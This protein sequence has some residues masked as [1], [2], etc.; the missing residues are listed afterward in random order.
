MIL[1]KAF[2]FLALIV[3]AYNAVIAFGSGS[4]GSV[5]GQV[6]LPSGVVWNVATADV[7]LIVALALLFVEIVSASSR[8]ASI[9]NHGLSLLVFLVC[10]V[11]FLLVPGC[12]TTTFLLITLMTLIDVIGG[13]SISIR[14][15]RR[16][17]SVERG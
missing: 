7:L 6:R 10:V 9:V 5:A 14:A 1:L 2:P 15:A 3:I 16:D 8:T 4:L 11:E 13:Y 17:L 12:G